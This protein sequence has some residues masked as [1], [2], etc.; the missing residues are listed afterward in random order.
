MDVAGQRT[1]Y[2]NQAVR[3][4]ALEGGFHPIGLVLPELEAYARLTEHAL[5]RALEDDFYQLILIFPTDSPDALKK[6][7]EEVK[8]FAIKNPQLVKSINLR[9]SCVGVGPGRMTRN[10]RRE[11][12]RPARLLDNR[13]VVR[14]FYL[15]LEERRM[16]SFATS[17]GFAPGFEINPCDPDDNLFVL[18]VRGDRYLAKP[19]DPATETFHRETLARERT[20]RAGLSG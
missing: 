8:S 20:F 12:L 14:A 3:T 11:H 5:L 2:I 7:I 6:N 9:I 18:L 19:A 13:V 4:L 1:S 16:F 15:S 17:W 10:E